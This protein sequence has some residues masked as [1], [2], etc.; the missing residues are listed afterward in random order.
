MPLRLAAV[1]VILLGSTILGPAAHAEEAAPAIAVEMVSP[2]VAADGEFVVRLEPSSEIPLDARFTY[3]IHQR[4]RTD[5]GSRLREQLE[6]L[7]GG[8]SPNGNLHGPETFPALLLGNPADGLELEIPIRSRSGDADRLLVP[9]QGI[10][11]VSLKIETVD[12]ETLWSETVYLNRLPDTEP[13]GRDGLPAY[14][15]VQVIAGID[16]TPTLSA[17]GDLELDAEERASIASV[18]SLLNES[19]DLPITLNAR[20]NTLLGL[21]RSTDPEDPAFVEEFSDAAWILGR[22]SYVRVDAAGLTAT[23][24]SELSR[25]ILEGDAFL[26][27]TG[28]LNTELWLL[29]DTVDTEAAHTLTTMGIK[30]LVMSPSAFIPLSTGG[31]GLESVRAFAVDTEPTMTVTAY[32]PALIRQLSETGTD[33]ALK[34]HR[35]TTAMMGSW[36]DAI[37]DPDD[38]FPGST[39][40]IVLPPNT[41]PETLR[42]L[43]EPLRES[44]PLRAATPTAAANDRGVPMTAS[45]VD[46]ETGD[47]TSVVGR[48]EAVRDQIDG[49]RSMTTERNQDALEWDLINSQA[50]AL[51]ADESQR[52]SLWSGVSESID[53]KV[54]RITG[55]EERTILLTSSSGTIPLRLNNGLDH[56]V[57]LLMSVRSPRLEFPQGSKSNIVLPPGESL[58]DIPIEVRA[59]GASLLRIRLSSPD[60]TIRLP[61]AV[62]PVRSSSISGVGAALSILSLGFLL[63]WWWRTHRRSKTQAAAGHPS[64]KTA[65]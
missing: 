24:R 50:P 15:A 2:W 6:V 29:D 10:H 4:L 48:T 41:E 40:T 33:P 51:S 5:D 28:N 39:A 30:H 64:S 46:R 14:T 11:P 61:E 58:I 17:Q 60:G 38:A 7:E 63:L 44:G 59:P 55:P 16:S 52:E 47:L 27:R 53:A 42:A 45:L 57:T 36:F 56:P 9:T 23:G 62:V 12:G 35:T 13:V 26:S 25:Q 37:S 19:T 65:E 3:V 34:A 54:A 1:F 20:P 43:M 8:E 22:Q 49:Y 18:Q 21:S 32:D 31:T